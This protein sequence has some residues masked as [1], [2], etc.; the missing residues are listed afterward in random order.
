MSYRLSILHHL[1][2]SNIGFRVKQVARMPG[3]LQ[4]TVH[5]WMHKRYAPEPQSREK[6]VKFL[7]C[8]PEPQ[9]RMMFAAND[10]GL[11]L[12]G[13]STREITSSRGVG[14]DYTP[15]SEEAS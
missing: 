13:K 7:G 6:I 2:P 10:V 11:L 14:G 3:V 1:I 4:L 5:N 8:D 9:P 15:E 12:P